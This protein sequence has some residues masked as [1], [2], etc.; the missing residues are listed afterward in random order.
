MNG[1]YNSQWIP[2]QQPPWRSE[3]TPSDYL[4]PDLR[5]AYTELVPDD[6]GVPS[7]RKQTFM[8]KYFGGIKRTL[9][10][11]V[12]VACIVLIINIVWLVYAKSK[13]GIVNGFGTIQ[14]GECSK[15][16]GLSTWY[17]LLINILSTLLLTGSNAFM[18]TYSCPSRQEVDH[19]HQRGKSLHVGSLSF[20]NLRCIAKRRG[21]VVLALALSSAPFHLLRVRIML[22]SIESLRTK[23]LDIIL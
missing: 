14:S 4:K 18:A 22:L 6:T 13:Y 15:V 12:A 2:M 9:R 11:F 23:C 5:G 7:Y 16:K 21:L 19:A 3:S 20:G 17:H 8:Q 1:Q 10:I